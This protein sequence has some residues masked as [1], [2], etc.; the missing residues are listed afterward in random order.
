[1]NTSFLKA[2][3]LLATLALLV[4]VAPASAADCPGRELQPTADN[5]AQVSQATLCLLNAQ[6]SAAG[7]RPVVEESS[8]TRLSVAYSQDMVAR[9][10]FEHVTPGGQ[11]LSER[12]DKIGYDWIMNGENIAWGQ[13]QLGTPD[14]IVD[15]WMNSPPHRH[16]ILNGDFR[17]IGL[18]I[19]IGAPQLAGSDAATYTTDF[20]TRAGGKVAT[21]RRAVA[22]QRS[23]VHHV[24]VGRLVRVFSHHH[25]HHS[26]HHMTRKH[27]LYLIWKARH[28]RG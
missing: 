7:L 8:L 16:N 1:M 21:P 11:T 23:R 19:A 22:S 20:G 12:L 13:R 3:P 24:R 6:R 25:R 14:S 27:R 15:A 9:H 28:H 18:G 2:L 17:E 5:L 4:P 10:Y 26:R